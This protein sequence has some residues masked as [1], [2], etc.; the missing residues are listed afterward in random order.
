MCGPDELDDWRLEGRRIIPLLP[1]AAPITGYTAIANKARQDID[2]LN[3]ELPPAWDT[4]S[5]V[6]LPPLQREDTSLE[7]AE[8]VKPEPVTDYPATTVAASQNGDSSGTPDKTIKTE[9]KEENNTSSTSLEDET[10]MI[11]LPSGM[12]VRLSSDADKS[13]GFG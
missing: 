3:K 8:F 1:R 10:G 6:P 12:A 5:V 13:T 4:R 7:A 9:I 11:F 2:S